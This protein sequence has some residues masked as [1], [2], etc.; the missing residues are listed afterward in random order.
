AVR[1]AARQIFHEVLSLSSH[2]RPLNKGGCQR[3]LGSGQGKSLARQLFGNTF[4]LIQ[5]LARLNLGYPVF[6]VTL[7]FTHPHLERLLGDRLV[8]ED[9]DPDFTATLDVT[10]QSTTCRFNLTG[11]QTTAADGFECVFAKAHFTAAMC[12]ATVVTG[13]LLAELRT[14]G[15]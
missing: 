14:L 2:H 8:R 6:D 11:G 15:L 13:H 7:T 5:D 3:Q 10:S 4:N 12:Q 1:S 9:T